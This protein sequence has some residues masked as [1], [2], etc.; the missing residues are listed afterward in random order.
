MK[1][2]VD[3]INEARNN[4][5]KKPF[6]KKLYKLYL[7]EDDSHKLGDIVE[8]TY[9][10]YSSYG[11][12]FTYGE[13]QGNSWVRATEIPENINDDEA[14]IK[15]YFEDDFK[16]NKTRKIFIDKSEAE[17]ES[18]KAIEEFDKQK[19]WT[20]EDLLENLEKDEDFKKLGYKL[21][22]GVS[23][24]QSKKESRE[25]ILLENNRMYR[26][27]IEDGYIYIEYSSW[28]T[29]KISTIY[30]VYKFFKDKDETTRCNISADYKNA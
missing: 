30:A 21:K 25:A 11:K 20:N 23:Q 29:Y 8:V 13:P 7:I 2:F 12:E 6:I 26:L 16:K 3:Y 22:I 15:K 19:E 1:S 17:E 24:S 9:R 10:F 28:R 14:K 4:D 5:E 27:W 18:K